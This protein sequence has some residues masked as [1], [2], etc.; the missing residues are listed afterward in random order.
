MVRTLLLCVTDT[1]LN[2]VVGTLLS[3]VVGTLP[4]WY[5]VGMGLSCVVGTLLLCVTDTLLYCVIGGRNT[6]ILCG[7]STTGHWAVT[8]G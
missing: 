5:D 4:V 8:R 3:C 1:L 6:T 2:C 7:R